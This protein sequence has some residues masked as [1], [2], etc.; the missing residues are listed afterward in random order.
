M[1][2]DTPLSEVALLLPVEGARILTERPVQVQIL[3]LELL[4]DQIIYWE[5][6]HV[7]LDPVQFNAV[8]NGFVVTTT[9]VL[10]PHLAR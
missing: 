7:V 10:V 1:R 9:T 6:Q 3:V 4:R 5:S 8:V 2:T